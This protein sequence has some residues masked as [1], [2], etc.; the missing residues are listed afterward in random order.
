MKTKKDLIVDI[1]MEQMEWKS[2]GQV[3]NIAD[4]IIELFIKPTIDKDYEDK[5]RENYY[6]TECGALEEID[7]CC[8]FYDEEEYEA[9]EEA[10]EERLMDIAM[11]CT[12]GAWRNI[13]GKVLHL[14]D[15][16]CGAE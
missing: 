12:C 1:I 15:C 10:E 9:I 2:E 11:R 5:I 13:N 7:C 16:C 4:E 14:A 8:E 6:C 3:S